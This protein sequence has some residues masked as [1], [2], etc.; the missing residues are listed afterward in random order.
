MKEEVVGI[1]S[2]TPLLSGEEKEK[3]RFQSASWRQEHRLL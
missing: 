2:K 3:K 1:S